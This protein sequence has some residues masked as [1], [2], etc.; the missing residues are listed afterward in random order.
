MEGGWGMLQLNT[1]SLIRVCTDRLFKHTAPCSSECGAARTHTAAQI[2]D[3]IHHTHTVCLSSCM[4]FLYNAALISQ[5]TEALSAFSQNMYSARSSRS[6]PTQIS[7]TR[8]HLW[9]WNANAAHSLMLRNLH[10]SIHGLLGATW[11]EAAAC[12]LNSPFCGSAFS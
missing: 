5:A 1:G 12:S 11:V 7:A 10:L 9:Y 8:M 3:W 4:R 2:N 6:A